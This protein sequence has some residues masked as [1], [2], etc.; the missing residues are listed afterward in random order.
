MVTRPASGCRLAQ[1]EMKWLP[2]N[3]GAGG[4]QR[5]P[6]NADCF[7]SP[8]APGV[9]GVSSPSVIRTL[10]SKDIPFDNRSLFSSAKF[11]PTTPSSLLHCSMLVLAR[12]AGSYL[13]VVFIPF[14]SLGKPREPKQIKTIWNYTNLKVCAAQSLPSAIGSPSSDV[15]SPDLVLLPRGCCAVCNSRACGKAS[16]GDAPGPLASAGSRAA[17]PPALH[18]P[19][20]KTPSFDSEIGARTRIR[21]RRTVSMLP[22]SWKQRN[23][24]IVLTPLPRPIRELLGSTFSSLPSVSLLWIRSGLF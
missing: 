2:Q 19:T 12:C 4:W 16:T 9:S 17:P 13:Y 5:G 11:P 7:F 1:P 6:A 3:R 24:H 23:T 14:C 21:E 8:R 18:S 10:L 15:H 20:V 22:A